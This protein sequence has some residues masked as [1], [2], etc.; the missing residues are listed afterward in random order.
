[1]D[2]NRE[3]W[4]G[5]CDNPD[6]IL[7]DRLDT[8]L[9]K[10]KATIVISS[11]WRLMS[12]YMDLWRLFAVLG[13]KGTMIGQTPELPSDRTRGDEIK[14]WLD[15]EAAGKHT[16]S[17]ELPGNCWGF[18]SKP[19]SIESFV[20]LDDDPD[21]GDLMPHLVRCDPQVGLSQKN[22]DEA[23]KILTGKP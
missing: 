15:D 8:L 20:I 18:S 2:R 22:V 6:P 9:T 11:T 1:M 19:R 4:G 14:K 5:F 23:L 17:E 12:N 13:F 7:L 10:S 21:M 3:R 16:Y